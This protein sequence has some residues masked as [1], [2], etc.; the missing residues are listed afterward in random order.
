VPDAPVN[1]TS[2]RTEESHLLADLRRQ[3]RDHRWQQQAL[4]RQRLWRRSVIGQYGQAPQVPESQTA[5]LVRST[6]HQS[7][8]LR[9][10]EAIN[11]GPIQ[12]R[13]DA[14]SNK[15]LTVR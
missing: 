11:S 3:T 6:R 4:Q 5:N 15:Y 8:K 1:V 2:C 14:A 10:G 9:C 7:G 13:H 12:V